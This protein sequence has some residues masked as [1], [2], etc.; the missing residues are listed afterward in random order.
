MIKI[1]VLLKIKNNFKIIIKNAEFLD[2]LNKTS[3][4][5]K[6]EELVN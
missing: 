6:L 4:N 1:K 2:E 3:T 5:E